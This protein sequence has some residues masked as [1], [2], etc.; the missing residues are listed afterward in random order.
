MDPSDKITASGD[1]GK[2]LHV[3]GWGA[4]LCVIPKPGHGPASQDD[5]AHH[6]WNFVNRVAHSHFT[7]GTTSLSTRF[8]YQ[9]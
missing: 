2:G 5:Q 3:A 9:H 8:F 1:V 4:C 6:G 7:D